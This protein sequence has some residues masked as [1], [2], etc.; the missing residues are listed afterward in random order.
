M[1]HAAPG[2]SLILSNPLICEPALSRS[3]LLQATVVPRSCNPIE[4]SQDRPRRPAK[5]ENTQ[6]ADSLVE[7]LATMPVKALDL[8]KSVFTFGDTIDL[9]PEAYYHFQ[10]KECVSFR[11]STD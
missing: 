8:Y 5:R 7:T 1:Q 2:F 11:T 3:T 6:S 9:L 10:E 4:G